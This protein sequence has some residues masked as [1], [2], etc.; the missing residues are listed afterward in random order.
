[1][2]WEQMNATVAWWGLMSGA[3]SIPLTWLSIANQW[4]ARQ[5]LAI[6]AGA[7]LWVFV[8]SLIIRNRQ[9][10]EKQKPRLKMLF[11]PS[12]DG[13]IMGEDFYAKL[14]RVAVQTCGLCHVEKCQGYLTKVE[15]AGENK[16]RGDSILLTFAPGEDEDATSKTIWQ[17][18]TKFLDLID[19]M[20]GEI[21]AIRKS[22]AWEPHLPRIKEI[23]PRV[24][25]YVLTIQI[26]AP[27]A[28][29]ITGQFKLTLTDNVTTTSLKEIT[30][31]LSQGAG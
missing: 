11:T 18:S 25:E 6:S 29:T 22:G 24:G 23:F 17:H 4:S 13:C 15:L 28:P 3:I 8:V 20:P 21:K 7:A 31:Q 2:V 19:V 12:L 26:V 14:F 5:T 10:L 27:S 9:L 16:L 1:M 30:E